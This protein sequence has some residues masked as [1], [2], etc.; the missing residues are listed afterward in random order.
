[1]QQKGKTKEGLELSVGFA[2]QFLFLVD[3]IHQHLDCLLK[4]DQLELFVQPEQ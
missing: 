2:K 3:R 4:V 1:M